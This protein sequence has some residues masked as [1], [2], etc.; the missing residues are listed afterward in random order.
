MWKFY[1]SW[2]RVRREDHREGKFPIYSILDRV[3]VET[4][5]GDLTIKGRG[6]YRYR[7]RYFS[8]PVDDKDQTLD[9][10]E[11]YYAVV[12]HLILLKVRP[13]KENEYR[14]FVFNEKLKNVVRIDAIKDACVLLPDKHGIIFPRGYYLQSGEY[15]L[16]DVQTDNFALTKEWTLQTERTSNTSFIIWK[17]ALYL[18]LLYNIIQQSLDPPIVFSGYSHFE[19]VR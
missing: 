9:D 3:F 16:F 17:P 10:A 2:A 15:K 8:E 6:Q 1:F 4:L 7:K 11:I 5:Q 19:K 12:G 14:Y 18:I 13:Y